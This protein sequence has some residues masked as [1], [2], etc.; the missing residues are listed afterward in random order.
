M[1]RGQRY[2]SEYSLPLCER[3]AFGFQEGFENKKT[4][5]HFAGVF[6]KHHTLPRAVG[7]DL[8]ACTLLGFGD[9]LSLDQE[10]GYVLYW[11]SEGFYKSD[12]H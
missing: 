9:V 4:R 1:K 5:T 7:A 6:A 10:F 12:N 2:F 8:Q 11:H 3:A